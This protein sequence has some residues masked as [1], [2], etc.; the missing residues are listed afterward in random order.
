MPRDFVCG[1]GRSRTCGRWR[2]GG[3]CAG[4]FQR[5]RTGALG[6]RGLGGVCAPGGKQTPQSRHR[7]LAARAFDDMR[8]LGGRCDHRTDEQ[9]PPGVEGDALAF[10]FGASTPVAVWTASTPR[11][12]IS[13]RSEGSKSSGP[14]T[15][16]S[17][18]EPNNGTSA[19]PPP[20]NSSTAIPPARPASSGKG[21]TSPHPIPRSN[22]PPTP[23]QTLIRSPTDHHN[24]HPTAS[25]IMNLSTYLRAG[26]PG[27]AVISSEE[28]RFPLLASHGARTSDRAPLHQNGF[29]ITES[30]GSMSSEREMCMVVSSP[31]VLQSW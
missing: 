13:V 8:R 28:A 21:K 20:A 23:C 9:W 30:P 11:R 24:P 22:D 12:S 3:S 4:S 1:V 25:E 19:A 29:S 31:M 15:S 26:Y 17:T 2:L 7:L 14:R 18:N 6:L 16:G 10:R 27:L 5:G